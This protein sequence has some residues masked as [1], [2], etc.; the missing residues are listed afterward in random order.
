M[1]SRSR[2]ATRRKSPASRRV[3]R[4]DQMQHGHADSRVPS[5]EMRRI[6]KR[7]RAGVANQGVDFA[8]LPGEIH[9]LVGENGAGKSTLM[10]MAAGIIQP[11]EGE[12]LVDGA[13]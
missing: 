4:R 12:I 5:L 11:D 8:V 9:S 6:T 10:R 2:A 1:R 7:F 3:E 13:V